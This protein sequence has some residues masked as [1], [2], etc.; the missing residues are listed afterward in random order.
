MLSND[1][2]IRIIGISIRPKAKRA[3]RLAKELEQWLN[4]RGCEVLCDATQASE[5][6]E[7]ASLK[8]MAK[9]VD[10]LV[11]LGGDGTLLHAARHFM[12]SNTPILGIN[13]GRLGFLTDTPV[14]SMFD[15][16]TSVLAGHFKTK[17]HFGLH[18]SCWRDG[19]CLKESIAMNDVILQRYTHPRPI[20]FEVTY[21]EQLMF[22]LHADGVIVATPAGSTAYA[23]SAGGPIVHP[24]VEAISVVPLCPHTLSNRPVL[25]PAD[26]VI[27]LKLLNSPKPSVLNLDGQECLI[28]SEGDEIHVK[29]AGEISL[30]YLPERH[31]FSTLRN[32]LHWAGHDNV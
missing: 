31:Y 16:M 9:R 23:L 12:D 21:R 27:V 1:V 6:N 8:M 17:H 20:E 30:I 28:L 2:D 25:I 29:K 5:E 32:K 15:V 10:L 14:G 13:L 18:A 19:E 4:K 24:D 11:V 3:K 26:D 7:T 22:R